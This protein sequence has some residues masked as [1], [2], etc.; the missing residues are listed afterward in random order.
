[1][2]VIVPSFFAPVFISI[3]VAGEGVVVRKSSERVSTMRT[4]RPTLIAAAATSASMM[5]YLA[6][7]PPPTVIGT[8][9]TLLLG[10]LEQA[11]NLVAHA[12]LALR[13]D[14]HRQAA[15]HDPARP[16]PRTAPCSVWWTIGVL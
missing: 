8:T 16:P 6:P 11:R 15:A 13:A 12:E 3:T 9:L 14:V 1:M 5:P 10:R 4:G 7:K 2:A